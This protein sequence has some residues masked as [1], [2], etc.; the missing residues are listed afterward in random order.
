MNTDEPGPRIGSR[1]WDALLADVL[2]ARS[3]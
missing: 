2:A 3:R 1:E